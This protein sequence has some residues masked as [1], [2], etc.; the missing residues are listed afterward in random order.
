MGVLIDE[1]L[2]WKDHVSKME[3]KLSKCLAILYKSSR[4]LDADSLRVLYCSLLLPYVNYCCEVWG[5]TYKSTT[6]CIILLQKKALR[7]ISKEDIRAPTSP[8]F[9]NL[10]LLKFTDLV[11]L[12][13]AIFMF[14]AHN[15]ELP[16]NLQN[17]FS[18][19]KNSEAYNL[20]CCDKFKTNFVR[21]TQMSH[22]IS[23]YGVK[24]YNS[25]PM[26]ITSKRH[27]VSFK[28]SYTKYLL[29]QYIETRLNDPVCG[30][31]FIVYSSFK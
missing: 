19:V 21:T 29:D 1:K 15:N 3:T 2:S 17:K 4:I 11:K 28:K 5:T 31:M 18:L 24:L 13:C 6:S 7:I 27:I 9:R 14:K 26:I 10:K 25:L 16:T 22:C 8:L 12:K 30:L 20:R 23:S